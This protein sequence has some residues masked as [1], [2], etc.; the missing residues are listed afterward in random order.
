[1]WRERRHRWEAVMRRRSGAT[2]VALFIL[3]T[4]GAVPAAA[5]DRAANEAKMLKLLN[6][7][8]ARRGLASLTV[9]KPLDRAALVHS[10]DMLSRDYF[11]HSS[12][13]GATVASRARRAGYSTSDCSQW[14]VG[15]VI[16]WGKSYKGTPESVFHVWMRSKSHRSI[17]LGK[18][19]RD[20]GIGCS[21][22]TYKGVSDVIMYTVDVGRRVQ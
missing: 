15:E 11:S 14:T 6:H 16:A 9:V 8:R 20:V 13:A 19:W 2:L 10:R 18:R 5:F 4:L 7:A 21:R 3:L 22:G 12:L 1:M 17:I